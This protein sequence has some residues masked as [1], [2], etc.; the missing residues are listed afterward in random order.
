MR[1][2]WKSVLALTLSA[3]MM[4]SSVPAQAQTVEATTKKFEQKVEKLTGTADEEKDFAEGEAIILYNTS[5]SKTKS[6]TSEGG[7]GTDIEVKET[8]DFGNESSNIKAKSTNSADAGFSVSLVKSDKYTTEE[9]I[10][11]L[12]K[13]TDVKYVEPNYR[14][15]K[16]DTNDTY[17][18]YQ[19]ALDNKGQNGGAEGLD[20]NADAE[21]MQN[22]VNRDEKVIALV[23]TGIDYNHEDLQDVV[24]NNPINSK[25]LKG[26]HG[27][28]FINYDEDPLDDNGHGTHC[29][30]IMAANPDNEIGIAGVANSDNIKIMALKI[31]DAEGYGYGMEAVGAYNYI[32]KAQQLGVNVVAVNN[33]WGETIYEE[34]GDDSDT[35]IL[36]EVINMVGEA[37]AVSV[38]AAGNEGVDNETVESY[39]ACLESPYIISVAASNENDEL[40]A[41]SNYGSNVDIAAPGADILSTVSYDVFN[42]TIY[43]NKD[44]LCS[45]YEDFETGNLVQTIEGYKLNG[46]TAEEGDIAYGLN[47]NGGNADMSVS[48]DENSYF[49]SGGK[50]IQWSIIGAR[51]GDVYTLYLPY[52]SQDSDTSLYSSVMTK[53]SGPAGEID[54]FWG[55]GGSYLGLADGVINKNGQYDEDSEEY[56]GET[57][58]DSGNYWTHCSGQVTYGS[59]KNQNRAIAIYVIAGADGD[60]IVNIDDMGV[61]KSNVSSESFG[62]YDFYNGTSMAAPHVTA[63]VAAVANSFDDETALERK[64]RII[65][66][67][68]DS[69]E[70]WGS[71][72]SNGVLDFANIENPGMFL[73]NA[74]INDKN[75]IE[76]SGYY[77]ND[78]EVYI[79]DEQVTPIENT[80]NLI[81]VDGKDYIC[82]SAYIEIIK[83]DDYVSGTYFFMSGK[84]FDKY[85]NITGYLDKG[86]IVSGADCLYYV[87]KDGYVAK[88]IPDE[89]EGCMNWE[90]GVNSYSTELFGTFYKTAVDYTMT[91]DTDIVCINKELYTVLSIDVGF[92]EESILVKYDEKDGWKKYTDLPEDFAE[93]TGSTLT[94]YN[95][96]IYLIG[97]LNEKNGKA[98]KQVKCYDENSKSWTQC[99]LLPEGRYFAKAKQVGD[100]LVVALGGNGTEEIPKTLIYDGSEWKESKADIGEAIDLSVY[101]YETEDDYYDVCYAD[102]QIGLVKSGIVFTNLKIEGLGDTFIYD[103]VN[104]KYISTGY[105]LDSDSLDGDQL[106][107]TTIKDKL[108][109]LYGWGIVDEDYELEFWKNQANESNDDSDYLDIILSLGLAS[110][111][112]VCTMPV[113][114]GYVCVND[115]SDSGAYVEGTGYYLPGDT[116]NLVAEALEGFSVKS[117]TVD[118]K[119]ISVDSKGKYTYTTK[120]TG[121]VEA[122]NVSAE[123]VKDAKD[124]VTDIIE[125]PSIKKGSKVEVGK[126]TYKVTN[127]SAKKKTVTVVSFNDKKK[128]TKAT[129]P[130]T[131]KING[132][133]FKVTAIGANVFKNCKKLKNVTI[134]K[135]VTSIGKNAFKGCKKL[136]KVTIKAAKIKKFGKGLF[137]GTDKKLVVKVPKKSK[138][139]YKTKLKKAGFTGK[140]K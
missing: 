41:F 55:V 138:K 134:G 114:N 25:Q 70:L 131:I 2:K 116:I 10:S 68:R 78:A 43:E 20:I 57:S 85:E 16:L 80:N 53:V 128:A 4:L 17:S 37:G 56:L 115:K 30:G 46:K 122:I 96:E 104:D 110:E 106:Y 95:G 15:K 136:K 63:A 89:N 61:S 127:M 130:A 65:G 40:A 60:Y 140:V 66:S 133:K 126:F 93:F 118:G 62:K 8:Y 21:V 73:E 11:I 105:C 12:K 34:Y 123:S 107:A 26:E 14:I 64:A 22:I 32:Y 48:I 29:S 91:N 18:Q 27:Y 54:E 90:E 3:S 112:N 42:P 5:S 137:K 120:V 33:S 6:I 124:D 24:W 99:M 23:D 44:E 92:A 139:S 19:W 58:V 52:T 76:I 113:S 84:S 109:V 69:E 71:V 108:Y 74:K 81:V 135:N 79:N 9:L 35:E 59:S 102:A 100:K 86:S 87:N 67:A 75:Q 47:D 49:G 125:T 82:K 97:G 88:G 39:P 121:N 83:E 51:E 13:R 72:S 36:L 31:L 119:K 117:F 38:C 28:D 103:I 7:L 94:S 50:S 111:I 101:S 132:T 129:V 45:V 98:S 1:L 77:M